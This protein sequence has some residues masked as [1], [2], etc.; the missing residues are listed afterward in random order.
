MDANI[1]IGELGVGH[2]DLDAGHVAVDAAAVGLDRD[3]R[4]R[5]RP[6]TAGPAGLCVRPP[7]CGPGCGMAIEA[8]GLVTGRLIWRRCGAGRGR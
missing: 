1:M 5:H 7:G 2:R 3:R 6:G 4:A 8:T